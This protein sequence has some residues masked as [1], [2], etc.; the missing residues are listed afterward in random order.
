MEQTQV[1][2]NSLKTNF[3]ISCIAN[4]VVFIIGVISVFFFGVLTCGLGCLLIVFP[5]INLVVGILDAIAMGKVMQAP[6]ASNYSFLKFT[7]ICEIV[8]FV[9]IVPII[10]GILNIQKLGSPEIYDYFHP[11]TSTP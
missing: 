8:A 7:A 10:M 3:L 9:G 5:F 11:S 1:I 2:L 4:A 6:S